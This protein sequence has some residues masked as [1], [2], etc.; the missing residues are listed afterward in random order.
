MALLR[1]VAGS[2]QMYHHFDITS[3]NNVY[4]EQ[5]RDTDYYHLVVCAESSVKQQE[6]LHAAMNHQTTDES[7]NFD[8]NLDQKI[9]DITNAN[10]LIKSHASFFKT[11]FIKYNE[12]KKDKILTD[13]ITKMVMSLGKSGF[14]FIAKNDTEIE[15]KI[16][17]AFE[18]F[19]KTR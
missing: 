14:K 9:I 6:L 18:D 12:N 17:S 7:Q 3:V 15:A 2:M 13:E 5:D 10:R 1:A 8:P 19:E 4:K 11:H 16:K